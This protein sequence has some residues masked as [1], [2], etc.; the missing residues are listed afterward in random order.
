MFY[1]YIL[2]SG[3]YGYLYV[4]HT[5]NLPQRLHQHQTKAFSTAYV[6]KHN[7]HHLMYYEVCDTRQAAK[8]R[9]KDLKKRPRNYKFKLIHTQNPNWEPITLAYLTNTKPISIF[10]LTTKLTTE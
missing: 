4:G 9:E 5:D 6:H 8:E 3:P 2:A 7:I 10:N 1:V